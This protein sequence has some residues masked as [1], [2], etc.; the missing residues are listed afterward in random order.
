MKIHLVDA[1]TDKAFAGNPAA[2]VLLDAEPTNFDWMQLLAMEMNQS[3]TCFVW[4]LK[5]NSQADWGLRWFT[6]G[7]EVQLCGHATLATAHILW[8]EALVSRDQ[9]ITFYTPLA[10]HYLTC[11]FNIEI[12]TVLMAFPEVSLTPAPLPAGLVEAL[13]NCKPTHSG[14]T[15]NG[16]LLLQFKT[17][18][19]VR[20]MTPDFR[21][22]LE[23][24]SDCVLVTALSDRP[25]FDVISRFFAPS[26]GIDEDPVTGSA[27]CILGPWWGKRLKQKSL[28]CFQA[29]RRGGVVQLELMDGKVYL[30][31]HAVSLMRGELQAAAVQ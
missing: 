4:P 21:A 30:S 10:G 25:G 2:V 8:Q 20:G 14:R 31:G 27:H 18:E 9:P 5:D 13:G 29:S 23:A 3:E 16:T 28:S 7:V 15:D 24:T 6:P 1:F 22:M 12:E 11:D 26:A 19:E 17:A